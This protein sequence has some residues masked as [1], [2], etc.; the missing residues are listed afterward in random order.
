MRLPRI[1][2]ILLVALAGLTGCSLKAKYGC[3]APDGVQCKSISEVYKR[4]QGPRA[5][6]PDHP[7]L[8]AARGAPPSA[9]PVP[10]ET[11]RPIRSAPKIMRVWIA[12]WIDDEGDLHQEG[13]LYMVVD[14]GKWAV[15]LPSVRSNGGPGERKLDLL[16][17]GK[18]SNLDE[19]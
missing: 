10:E 12:P 13:F 16:E 6:S 11:P 5:P 17:Q 18:G 9:A 14:E 15:G 3:P 7:A 19:E 8:R 1:L 2:P 4:T